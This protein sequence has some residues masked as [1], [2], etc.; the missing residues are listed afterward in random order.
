[1]GGMAKS[2]LVAGLIAAVIWM[3]ISTAVGMD[4]VPVIVGGLAFL[5]GAGLIT[6]LISFLVV[7]ARTTRA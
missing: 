5:V 1:M 3:I 2:A 4:K 6:A 7:K